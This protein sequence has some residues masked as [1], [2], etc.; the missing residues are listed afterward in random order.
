MYIMMTKRAP[1]LQIAVS[2]M[3]TLLSSMSILP[4]EA[5]PV[6]VA[7]DFFSSTY[8]C[9]MNIARVMHRST[10]AMADAPALS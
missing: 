7:V 1:R 4:L 5:F 2:G 6:S 9:S 8:F 3:R 10:T